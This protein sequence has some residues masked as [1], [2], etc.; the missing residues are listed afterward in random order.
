MCIL[1]ELILKTNYE[2]DQII[3]SILQMDRL[4]LRNVN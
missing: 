3:V 4:G 2:L 1:L